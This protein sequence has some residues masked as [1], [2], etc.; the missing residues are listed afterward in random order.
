MA[1]PPPPT[2]DIPSCYPP[3]HRLAPLSAP[4]KVLVHDFATT[5]CEVTA[6]LSE[7]HRKPQLAAGEY[8]VRAGT[9]LHVRAQRNRG[10]VACSGHRGK[11]AGR[12]QQ[13]YTG[14]P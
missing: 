5:H 7:A 2:A 10:S 3:C 11:G 1:L 14:G 6:T 12:A 9:V 4:G 8:E 13:P